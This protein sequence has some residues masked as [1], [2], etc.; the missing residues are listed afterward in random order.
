M[1]TIT[2]T[3]TSVKLLSGMLL[4][5]VL[6]TPMVAEAGRGHHHHH[7]HHGH[8]H[9]HHK[10]KHHHHGHNHYYQRNIYYGQPYYPPVPPANVYYNRPYYPPAPVYYPPAPAAYGVAPGHL[11]MGINTGNV[12]VMLGF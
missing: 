4:S 10:H 7:H 3:N 1:K 11:F 9:H 8:H 2:K 12:G 5:V 6:A